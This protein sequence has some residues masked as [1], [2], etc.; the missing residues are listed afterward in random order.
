VRC[1]VAAEQ[2]RRSGSKY[3]VDGESF[4]LVV[5][6]APLPLVEVCVHRHPAAIRADI[7]ALRPISLLNLM[8][9]VKLPEPREAELDLPAVAEQ[10]P[11]NRVTYFSNYSPHN[12]PTGHGSFLA[13]ITHRANSRRPRLGA[14][15][16]RGPRS[17]RH[18]A[19]EHV[20]LTEWCNN[21]FAY[22]DQDLDFGA[23]IGRVRA[24][25]DNS[26]Y[27]TFGRFGRYEYHNSD[28]CIAR[29]IEVHAHIAEIARTGAP[30]R[31]GCSRS[32]PT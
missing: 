22:I 15:R 32:Q 4:D 29:A 1:G 10:G 24:W 7:R 5:N 27:I 17:R 3:L 21:E 25:F 31:R 9:G 13:E 18:P 20:V 11:T 30:R 12:A 6:T 26:G 14:E 16:D 2:V 19:S 23:R 28:Q 8:I